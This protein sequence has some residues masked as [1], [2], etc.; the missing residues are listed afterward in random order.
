MTKRDLTN[1]QFRKL[2][3]SDADSF[4]GV[5]KNSLYE[6]KYNDRFVGNYHHVLKELEIIGDPDQNHP[7]VFWLMNNSLVSP[8]EFQRL[9][10]GGWLYSEKHR[11]AD[12][13]YWNSQDTETI[14][15]FL[16]K[17]RNKLAQVFLVENE[18]L[19]DASDR[20]K[21]IQIALKYEIE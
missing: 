10:D 3:A 21:L 9:Q 6:I 7:L 14:L 2:L 19:V 11:S 8:I 13:E 5:Q 16:I 12:V 20:Q 17:H 15:N 18:Q 1:E 4:S